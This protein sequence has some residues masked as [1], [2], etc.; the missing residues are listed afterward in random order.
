MVTLKEFY[1]TRKWKE[2]A[3]LIKL[4]RADDDGNIICDYCGKPIAS[5]YD[6]IAHHCNTYL[7][8]SN[9]NDAT[10]AFNPDNIQL[11]HHRCH[12]L[13]HEKFGF[14]RRE[15][16]LVYGPPLS[17]K[18]TWVKS[19]MIPGD[20]IVDIDN[21]WQCVSGLNRYQKPNCLKAPVFKVR[22]T[23]LDIV[24]YKV[25]KWHNCYVV[26]T[27][28]ALSDRERLCDEL[29][30]RPIFIETSKEECFKRLERGCD[31]R[32]KD[33]WKKYIEDW[34]EKYELYGIPSQIS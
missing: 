8:E 9:V 11:V 16:Y 1:H 24:K 2:F 21:I 19:N 25:G 23:L 29:G 3:R 12:N 4:E 30:A 31:G 20:L 5:S 26:M 28:P 18:T 17:G 6:C 33:E 10:I 34:F 15:V 7:T 13:I 14:K 22:D 32:D 27:M